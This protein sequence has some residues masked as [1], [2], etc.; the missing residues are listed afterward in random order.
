MPGGTCSAT[1][2]CPT[3]CSGYVGGWGASLLLQWLSFVLLVVTV[4]LRQWFWGGSSP[5]VQVGLWTTTNFYTRLLDDSTLERI[6]NIHTFKALRAF[7]ILSVV[8]TLS[9]AIL[10]AVRLYRQQRRRFI[11]RQLEWST[12]AMAVTSLVCVVV[13]MALG[14]AVV[15]NLKFASVGSLWNPGDGLRL[16]YT[17]SAMMLIAT[18]LHIITTV[19]YHRAKSRASEDSSGVPAALLEQ[20]QPQQQHEYR[21]EGQVAP[22]DGDVSS[23][24][25][26][27][28]S[29]N[30]A[31]PSTTTTIAASSSYFSHPSAYQ[32][33][34][35]SSSDT[36]QYQV[37]L[38]G[39]AAAPVD[40]KPQW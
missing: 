15:V 38:S 3:F 5:T 37:Y 8:F 10:A 22:R 24:S 31:G 6:T 39:V 23:N 36:A 16:L 20:Q 29:H 12:C 1:G 14:T 28:L 17:A 18:P 30:D 21:S 32:P 11:S 13:A 7:T 19:Q 40:M 26:V 34:T 25:N 33:P 27:N 2:S 35:R 4:P 9:S